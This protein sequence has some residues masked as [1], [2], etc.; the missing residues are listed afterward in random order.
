MRGGWGKLFGSRREARA[1]RW[2]GCLC[3]RMWSRETSQRVS[4]FGSVG[5]WGAKLGL[6]HGM[7][8]EGDCGYR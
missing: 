3:G 1:R 4:V 2:G 7:V 8:V 6:G 5:V